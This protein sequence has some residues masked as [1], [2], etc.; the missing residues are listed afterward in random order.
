MKLI[1]ASNNAHKVRE[2]RE[3]LGAY[4]SHIVTLAEAGIHIEVEEDGKTFIENA[5]KKARA[6]LAVSDADAALSDDS[7]LMVDALDGAP[8]IYSARFAGDAHDDAANNRRL[9]EVMRDIPPARRAC[10]FV[11]A[12]AL[13]ERDGGMLCAE[14]SVEGELLCAP[15]GQSGFGYDPLFY[16]GPLHKS[17][18]ELSAEEKNSISHRKRALTALCGLLEA[19]RD[20]APR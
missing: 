20:Q 2:I 18:A 10:R 14:G 16:Y 6:V 3:I 15:R 19:R 1:I 8:G 9:L 7:G 12:V 4:F 11:C 5:Q 17:F 13:A